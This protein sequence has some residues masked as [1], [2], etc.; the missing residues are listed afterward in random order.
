MRY[1][2]LKDRIA[3]GQF[4]LYWSP[5]KSNSADYF[6]KHHPPA[7][8]KLMRSQYLHHA[9]TALHATPPVQ[10]FVS[11][12]SCPSGFSIPQMTPRA[13]VL[14]RLSPFISLIY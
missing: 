10:G 2:W 13:L 14:G 5:G 7:H 8:H 1:H 11:P 4:N 6:S 12:S 3:Q 9:L